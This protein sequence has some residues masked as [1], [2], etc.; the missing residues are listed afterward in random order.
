M[1]IERFEVS[2]QYQCVV[3][4]VGNPGF[5]HSLTLDHI[6]ACKNTLGLYTLCNRS[7]NHIFTILGSKG[8]PLENFTFDLDI[9]KTIPLSENEKQWSW[10]SRTPKIFRLMTRTMILALQSI[11]FG[12]IISLLSLSLSFSGGERQS[13]F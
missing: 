12:N 4:V 6:S 3:V 8:K 9:P 2:Q 7:K 11:G 1:G 10:K 13:L 5:L